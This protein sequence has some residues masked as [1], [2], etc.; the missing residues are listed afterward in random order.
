MQ[1]K[2]TESP[3][4]SA[5]RKSEFTAGSQHFQDGTKPRASKIILDDKLSSSFQRFRSVT[6]EPRACVFGLLQSVPCIDSVAAT[7][8]Y[9]RGG[10]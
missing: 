10:R 4:S 6:P 1:R 5:S 9:R 8:F 7:R 3:E 2:V